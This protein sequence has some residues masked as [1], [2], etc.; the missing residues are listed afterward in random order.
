MK[1][2]LKILIVDDDDSFR[3]VLSENV[4]SEGFDA[5]QAED[6]SAA[7]DILARGDVP[8]LLLTDIK[9]PVMDGYELIRRAK[10]KYPSLPVIAITAHGSIKGAVEAMRLGADNY[11]TKP[12][13][14]K[15]LRAIIKETITADRKPAKPGAAAEYIFESPE[16]KKILKQVGKA[17]GSHATVLITGETGTGK[18]AVADL[19]HEGSGR[20]PF[21]K[22][23]CSAVPRDLLESEFF[24]HRKGA[25][26]G[27]AYDKK[28]KFVEADKGSILLD[29]IGEMDSGLQAKLLRVIEEK[30]VDVVGG[31]SVSVDVRVIA[32]TNQSPED[33]VKQGRFRE[34][35]F[36]RLN[37]I[38]IDVPPLRERK[39]DIE[40][41]A[42]RFIAAAAGDEKITLAPEV[43]AALH[44]YEW[45]GNVRELKNL[46]ERL[47][48]LRESDAIGLDDLPRHVKSGAPAAAPGLAPSGPGGEGMSLGDIEKQ[49][50]TEALERN[51]WNQS[52]AAR[53]LNI[54]RHVLLYRMEKYGIKPPQPRER[55]KP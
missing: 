52:A 32:S 13:D 38:R 12:Y 28:G 23:N 2:K 24:G 49:I 41:L 50:I 54:A 36:Y 51:K 20:E 22:V 9:M 21:V 11:V 43:M 26:T 44:D 7:L 31:G 39:D 55:K 1:D 5:I 14:R 42:L 40:P 35:L 53:S 6:G 3:E 19:V 15:E 18:E 37:V 25:F 8:A 30:K 46:C 17:A 10:Y 34:D 27:A 29:E 47:V 4:K 33:L 48:V 16:M 45:P